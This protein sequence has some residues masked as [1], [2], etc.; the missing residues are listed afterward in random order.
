MKKLYLLLVI[1]L[2]SAFIVIGCSS[3]ATTTTAPSATA[4]AVTTPKP[5]PPAATTP[6]ASSPAVSSPAASSP[7][8]S[9]PAASPKPSASTSPSVA[10]PKLGGTMNVIIDSVPPTSI[11][12]PPDLLG[13][14]TS[15]PQLCMEG[16]LREDMLRRDGSYGDMIIPFVLTLPSGAI[17]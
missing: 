12:Y 10:T 9:S 14:A 6:V 4:P 7:A 3:P 11:G 17:I 8:A 1:L 15:A 13:D 5:T 16:L 2:V